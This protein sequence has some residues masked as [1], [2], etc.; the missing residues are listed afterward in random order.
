M[1][2]VVIG[3]PSS[4]A[5]YNEEHERAENGV[6]IWPSTRCGGVAKPL[7]M[8]FSSKLGRETGGEESRRY[9]ETM[10]LHSP[11]SSWQASYIRSGDSRLPD[12]PDLRVQTREIKNDVMRLARLN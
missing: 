11:A 12:R 3:W 1:I 2:W 10:M 6:G 9:Q 7:G 5:S 4:R 8:W